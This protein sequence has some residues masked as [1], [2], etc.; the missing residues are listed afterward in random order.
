MAAHLE[1]PS[2]HLAR[3]LLLDLNEWRNVYY[4][5]TKA[6]LHPRLGLWKDKDHSPSWSALGFSHGPDKFLVLSYPLLKVKKWKEYSVISNLRWTGLNYSTKMNPTMESLGP[7]QLL[8]ACLSLEFSG[9]LVFH[10][11]II[12]SSQ[13][14][15]EVTADVPTRCTAAMQARKQQHCCMSSRRDGFP[16]LQRRGTWPKA[17]K[18]AKLHAWRENRTGYLER[19]Q[20]MS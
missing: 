10:V 17:Q 8:M 20:D 11:D 1:P 2:A 14:A 4:K 3:K 6:K 5:Y 9:A 13:K 15:H 12:N 19:D 18:M 7:M 16:A